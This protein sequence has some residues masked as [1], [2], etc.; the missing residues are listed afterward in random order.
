M[1]ARSLVLILVCNQSVNQAS[2]PISMAN[3]LPP[4]ILSSRA[5]QAVTKFGNGLTSLRDS[6]VTARNIKSLNPKITPL[7]YSQV[8]HLR[9][10]DSDIRIVG[11]VAFAT[12]LPV[13]G[14]LPMAL[15]LARPK[16]FLTRHFWSPEERDEYYEEER[17]DRRRND[18][19]VLDFVDGAYSVDKLRGA[20]RGRGGVGGE[21][22]EVFG[23]GGELGVEKI[24]GGKV[25]KAVAKG[26]GVGGGI[27]GLVGLEGRRVKEWVGIIKRE[28]RLLDGL[29]TSPHSK[30]T[31]EEIADAC[32]LRG[33]KKGEEGVDLWCRGTRYGDVPDGLMAVYGAV[34]NDELQ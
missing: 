1:K 2:T 31:D 24:M 10:F 28:D 11:P 23:E 22:W 7:T 29:L 16:T 17:V 18:E 33:V 3:Y 8:S 14:Y 32:H 6:Y 15:A 25:G 19:E 5:Y 9:R 26:N 34:T 27:S 13:V 4:S 30:L 12:L 21:V 20:L